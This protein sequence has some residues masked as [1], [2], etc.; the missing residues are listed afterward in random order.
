MRLFVRLLSLYLLLWSFGINASASDPVRAELIQ[1]GQEIVPGHPFQVAIRLKIEPDWHLYWKNPG[2][3]GLPISVSW[4]LPP[5]FHAGPLSWAF[6]EKFIVDEQVLFGYR[7]EAIL[8]ATLTPP[9][10]AIENPLSPIAAEVSWLV[11]SDQ[12]CRPGAVKIQLRPGPEDGGAFFRKAAA[13]IPLSV[14]GL[15]VEK[16][17]EGIQLEI[18]VDLSE[19]TALIGAEFFPESTEGGADLSAAPSLSWATFPSSCAV[20]LKTKGQSADAGSSL[21]GV[22]VLKTREGENEQVRPFEIDLFREEVVA[23]LDQPAYRMGEVQTVSGADSSIDFEGGMGLALLFAFLGGMLLNLM[24]CVLPVLSIKVMSFLRMSRESTSLRVK[25]GLAFTAGVILSFWVLAAVLLLLRHYGQAVGW[26]FQ[27]QEPLFVALLASFLFLMGLNLLGVFEWGMIF[28]SWAGQTAADRSSK[29]GGYAGSFLN[30]VVATAVATPCTGP[31][32]GSAVGFALAVPEMQAFL[33]FTVVA[34]GVSFPYLLLAL[35]PGWLKFVPKPGPWM[36]IFKGIMGFLLLGTVV[37]LLWVFSAETN[38][39]AFILLISALFCFG[40][41]AWIYGQCGRLLGPSKYKKFGYA[42]MLIFLGAGMQIIVLSRSLWDVQDSFSGSQGILALQEEGG[43]GAHY[44]DWEP[45]SPQR[46]AELRAQGVPV[47]IDFTAKWC[48]ICQSN[49]LSLASEAV[50]KKFRE[51]GV[52]KM[53][54]DW[55][56]HDAVITRALASFGR[57]SVPL[58]VLY[59]KDPSAAPLILPQVLTPSVILNYLGSV[60]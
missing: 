34:C 9:S 31:F 55:T 48:I 27:L 12:A 58:Y 17:E 33:I 39:L 46:V 56:R 38:A 53:K 14:E 4:Q 25:H 29:W 42:S 51:A 15:R 5:G 6:P 1:E 49:H 50:E 44:A 30:G 41:A 16:K 43:R 20:Y 37:W 13:K 47:F 24:P 28:A 35:F 3:I 36:E 19:K 8:L 11:C 59:G 22:L 2:E 45:F 26:G 18:P 10:T 32:L 40:V 60:H 21:K 57:S 52:V 23:V 54:A 7:D